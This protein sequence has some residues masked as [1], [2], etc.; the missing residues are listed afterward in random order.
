MTTPVHRHRPFTV[1][2]DKEMAEVLGS[3]PVVLDADGL[4][5]LKAEDTITGDRV[6]LTY[7]AITASVRYRWRQGDVV[8]VDIYREGVFEIRIAGEPKDKLE[9]LFRVDGTDGNLT[10]RI[11]PP[12]AVDDAMAGV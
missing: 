5:R 9:I 12:F 8:L 2:T 7:D 6:D 1:P 11:A 4:K 10:L 3:R